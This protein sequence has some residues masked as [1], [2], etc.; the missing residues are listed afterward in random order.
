M[1]TSTIIIIIVVL[2]IGI[3]I[4]YIILPILFES[5]GAGI[6]EN[7]FGSS[8]GVSPPSMPP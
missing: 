3:L 8:P 6:G 7:V 1:K 2:A 4:G 5:A